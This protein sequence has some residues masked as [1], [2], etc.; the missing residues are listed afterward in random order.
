M[1]DEMIVY[2]QQLEILA[3]FSGYPLVYAIVA[4]LKGKPKSRSSIKTSAF[5]LLP[6]AYAIVGILYAGLQIKNLYPDYSVE[7]IVSEI[8]IPFFAGWAILSLVFWIPFFRK[9]PVIS[10]L[11]SL[12]FFYLIVKNFYSQLTNTEPDKHVLGNLMKVYSDSILLNTIILI[13][14]LIIYYGARFLRQKS[15]LPH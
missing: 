8:Q 6:F 12:I 10:L 15:S 3:F 5:T 7:H 1:G 4:F 9:K 11:H 14:L 13:L 2:L